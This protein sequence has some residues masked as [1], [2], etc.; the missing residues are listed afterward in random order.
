[1]LSKPEHIS[2]LQNGQQ[3][4]HRLRDWSDGDI[5]FGVRSYNAAGGYTAS[6]GK[7]FQDE[8]RA[9]SMFNGSPVLGNKEDFDV[10]LF[11]AVIRGPKRDPADPYDPGEPPSQYATLESV[12]ILD[13][14]P[15]QLD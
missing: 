10:I 11:K 13:R 12:E 7:T 8:G 9:R 4:I 5:L 14:K 15:P 6:S 3:M 2:R 1:M